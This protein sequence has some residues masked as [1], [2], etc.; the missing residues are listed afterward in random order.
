MEE[1]LY[2]SIIDNNT[3]AEEKTIVY[4]ED[5]SETYYLE[6][7]DLNKGRL[8]IRYEVIHH[9][10][11]EAIEEISH[12]EVVAEYPNGGKDVEKI[13]D[14]PG[15]EGKE[16]Y[17]E[18]V[19]YQVWIPYTET[20]IRL[21]EIEEELKNFKEMLT[22]TDY[23]AIKYAEGWYTE[24]KYAPIKEDREGWRQNI[25]ALEK[26]QAILLGLPYEE[27]EEEE[28][29]TS[30]LHENELPEEIEMVETEA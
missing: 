17:D 24:E 16:A 11:I 10:A 8:E 3:T 28:T 1:M 27:E 6:D 23:Q 12:Y 30:N 21:R 19:E 26:E 2:D 18:T 20:D 29:V 4:N 15:K 9:E 7:L 13:I 22:N 25:R 14:S 5:K